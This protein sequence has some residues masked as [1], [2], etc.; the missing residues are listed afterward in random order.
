MAEP[1]DLNTVFSKEL[2]CDNTTVIDIEQ[3]RYMMDSD[4][5]FR[6][7]FEGTTQQVLDTVAETEDLTGEIKVM[8]ESESATLPPLALLLPFNKEEKQMV[9]SYR[10]V[11]VLLPRTIETLEGPQMGWRELGSFML[12]DTDTLE[13]L[14]N[15]VVN[16]YM[17]GVKC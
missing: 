3:D 13:N 9:H 16:R 7:P 15:Y 2:A 6:P 5:M 14:G 4:I 11:N 17:R 8:F 10:W 12:N 1:K